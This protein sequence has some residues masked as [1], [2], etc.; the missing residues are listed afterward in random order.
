MIR[1]QRRPDIMGLLQDVS[2]ISDE[3]REGL[4]S[5]KVPDRAGDD[6]DMDL[7]QVLKDAISQIEIYTRHC[8]DKCRQGTDL[9]PSQEQRL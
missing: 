6:H 8:R 9:G 1:A 4:W 7:A 3:L 5:G 2:E